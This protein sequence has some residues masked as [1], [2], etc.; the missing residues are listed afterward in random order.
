MAR[1][2]LKQFISVILL[3]VVVFG[4]GYTNQA[5]LPNGIQSIYVPTFK[6]ELT[7]ETIDTYEAGIATL[8]TNA[9]I[10]RL[11]FDGNLKVMPQEE[12]D[13]TLTGTLRGYDQRSIRFEDRSDVK[14]YR[15]FITVD[16]NLIDNRTGETIWSEK[17]FT[18]KSEY[19]RRG[20]GA[21][22]ER[23]ALLSAR[24]DLAK[25]VVDR[26]VEDW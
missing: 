5:I 8:V 22:T 10:D 7:K 11:I 20:F 14:E 3:S 23:T 4:C 26:I 25:K 1:S 9:V 6:D 12:A 16:L 13:A 24:D 19:N 17:G 18:G 2:Y 21:T 15:L